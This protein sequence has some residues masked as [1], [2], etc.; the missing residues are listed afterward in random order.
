M[1]QLDHEEEQPVP[2][3]PVSGAGYAENCIPLENKCNVT[4][5]TA[6]EE[7][8]VAGLSPGET[9]P[10]YLAQGRRRAVTTR[11]AYSYRSASA[12]KIRAADHEG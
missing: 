2:A 3:I 9:G 6:R 10:F 7:R 11:K 5:V 8:V 12:G 4:V 1:I